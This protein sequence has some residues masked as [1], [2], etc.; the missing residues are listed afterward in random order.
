MNIEN[1]PLVSVVI[2][3]YNHKNY[4]VKTIESVIENTYNNIQ[5]IVIDDG[6]KDGSQE[7]LTVLQDKYN[8]E[9][10]LQKNKGLTAT[11]NYAIENYIKGAYVKFLSSDDLL[12]K[13]SITNAVNY[14]ET[15]KDVE[16]LI[17]AYTKIDDNENEIRTHKPSLKGKLNYKNFVKG[18]IKFN[19]TAIFFRRIFFKKYGGYEEGVISEDLYLHRKIFKF[20][21]VML[22]DFKLSKY[23]IHENNTTNNTW[24][25]YQEGLKSLNSY[26][27]DKYYKHKKRIEYLN[28]FVLLSSNYKKEA[29][30]YLLPSMRFFYKRLFIIGLLNFTNISKLL[31]K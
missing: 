2:P 9:L 17:G 7:V 30:K 11:L 15:N 29:L 28:Y 1:A 3:S 10:Y 23:R 25:M 13:N 26:K 19:T 21:K 12:P 14:L 27:G 5:L 18:N 6:S 8:F 31:K 16:V 24:L 22:V 20:S 4:I